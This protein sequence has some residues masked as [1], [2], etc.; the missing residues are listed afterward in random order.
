MSFPFSKIK[1]FLLDTLFP[2]VCFSCRRFLDSADSVLC[3]ACRR[4][5]PL[6]NSLFCPFCR[7]RFP[8]SRPTCSCSLPFLFG[9]PAS[10]SNPAVRALIHA[11][12]FK[13]LAS[14]LNPLITLLI[15][16]AQ[17]LNFNFTNYVVVPIPL[18]SARERTRGFNQAELIARSLSKA[19]NLSLVPALKRI[20]TT[21]P[22][23]ELKSKAARLANIASAFTLSNPATIL[24][25]NIIL[26][27]DVY[28]TG[29]TILE[30]V[31]VLKKSFPRAKILVLTLAKS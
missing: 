13:K 7:A 2:P 14:A 28:T 1:I 30:A 15:A 29:A 3:S 19:L 31:R 18:S 5:L 16:Y 24:N 6:Y 22:Q 26:I 27:D 8:E 12:K 4:S 17:N 25:Q 10:F 9:A 11:T 20:K 23:A 21:K